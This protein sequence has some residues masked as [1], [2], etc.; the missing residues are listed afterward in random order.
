MVTPAETAVTR[1]PETVATPGAE[2]VQVPPGVASVKVVVPPIHNTADAADSGAGLGLTVTV[3]AAI[4][5]VHP[6]RP[7]VTE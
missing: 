1:P 7:A 4:P 5:D 3:V 2:L 6:L